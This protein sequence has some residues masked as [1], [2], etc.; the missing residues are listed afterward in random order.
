[1]TVRRFL[2]SRRRAL[3]GIA[4]SVLL[5]MA[6]PAHAA[7]VASPPDNQVTSLA[8]ASLPPVPMLPQGTDVLDYVPADVTIE[9]GESLTYV[10][11]DAAPHDVTSR[12]GD[13]DDEPLFAS[14]TI[15]TGTAGVE[16]VEL[17]A[18]GTYD[19]FCTIHPEMQGTLTVIAE[20]P[21]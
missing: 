4:V 20:G 10:N 7:E 1:M 11:L 12:D 8:G 3:V 15:T 2:L 16:G 17:L 5:G 9:E 21:S 18:A 13:A 19:F 6:W 14:P